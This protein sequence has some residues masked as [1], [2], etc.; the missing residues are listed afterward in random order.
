MEYT[1]NL[2]LCFLTGIFLKIYDDITDN[3]LKVDVFYVDLLKYFVITLFS[4][5]L[6]NDGVFSTLVFIMSITSL[7]MDKYYIIT[8]DEK[9][10]GKDLSCF[11][12]NVWIYVLILSGVFMIYHGIINYNI[13]F[14]CK[15]ITFIINIFINIILCIFEVYF[16]PEHI[17]NKKLYIRICVLIILI[18]F[19]YYMTQFSD[20]IYEGNYGIF[21]M[22]IGCFISSV[23]FLTLDKFNMFDYLKLE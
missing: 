13:K 23:C 9:K 17:S 5:S 4:I 19:F 7:L 10:T 22:S 15:Q 12:D 14:D 16:N 8:L 18:I 6:Y 11:N 20:Y 2:L 21:L 1:V 3:K